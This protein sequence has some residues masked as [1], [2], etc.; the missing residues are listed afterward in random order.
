VGRTWRRTLAIGAAAATVAALTSYRADATP[1]GPRSAPRFGAPVRVTPPLG[2]GYE[3][4]VVVDRF[5]NLFSTAHKENWQLVLAPDVNS[6][7]YTRSMSWAWVSTDDGQTWKDIPGLTELSLE[8][9]QFGDEG[10]MAFDDA[11]HLYFVDT[12]VVDD[13]LTRWTTTGRGLDHITL[14]FT[15]PII[16]TVEP[17]DDR[18]WITAHGDGSVFY[19]ANQGLKQPGGGRFTVYHSTNGGMTFDLGQKLE[20]SGWC[21]PTAD[22]RRGSPYVYVACTNFGLDQL[23]GTPGKL[24]TYV[25]VDD[26]D[27]WVRYDMGSYNKDDL[28]QTYPSVVVAPNGFVYVLYVDGVGVD[29]STGIP[30]RNRLRLFTSIDDGVHWTEQ[31]ITPRKGRYEYA[32]LSVSPTDPRLL[33]MGVYYRQDNESYWRVFG[34][35]WRAGQV[36]TLVSLDQG[37]PVAAPDETDAPG[38]YLGSAFDRRN[39]LSVVWTRRNQSIAGE[40]S[41]REI[42]FA[43]TL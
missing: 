34:A 19:I 1:P 6:P 22:H 16:P 37:H 15:R 17:L 33:G 31:D 4:T 29:D 12:T 7:L 39:H 24:Y 26:G 27:S 2:F 28:T 20:D 30:A 3:P 35:T 38:D 41:F 23:T 9:R 5:G 42:Y 25:S 13:T 10:D 18:P 14:D 40:V 43:R 11:D 36:P 32:W 8:Q 21:R